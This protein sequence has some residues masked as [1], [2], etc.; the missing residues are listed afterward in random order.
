[1]LWRPIF[2]TVF[3]RL[4]RLGLQL[5]MFPHAPNVNDTRVAGL[6]HQL[7]PEGKPVYIDV[8]PVR[9]AK[10]KGCFPAVLEQ[11]RQHGGAMVSGWQLWESSVILEAEY[12]AV[13]QAPDGVLHDITPKELPIERILF[14][15]DP[16]RPYNGAS[17]DNIRLNISGNPLVDAEIAIA[18]ALF[19][20]ENCGAR[21]YQCEV[22]LTH[23][24]A[25]ARDFLIKQRGPLAAMI[26]RKLTVDSPCYCKSRQPFRACHAPLIWQA[27]LVCKPQPTCE[28][29]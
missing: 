3:R 7:V 11:M 16:A 5:S 18:E 1:M 23:Q 9:F 26:L 21:A 6:V 19:A 25:A 4:R 20:V 8:T 22:T 15:P 17:R 14:L 13:W 27:I 28:D 2:F 10:V 24:E 29:E 12:H